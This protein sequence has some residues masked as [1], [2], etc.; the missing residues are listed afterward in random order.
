MLN[1]VVRLDN[2]FKDVS[3]RRHKRH[4]P[5]RPL[6]VE[7][8]EDRRVLATFTVTTS[9]DSG[10]GSLREAIGSANALPGVDMVVFDPNIPNLTVNLTTSELMITEGLVIDASDLPQQITINTEMADPTPMVNDGAGIRAIHIDAVSYTHLTLP[11][12]RE[13]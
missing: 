13:V 12:N 6:F 10:S 11:T 3:Q 7:P 1:Q 4:W 5:S 8:L 9:A 2:F